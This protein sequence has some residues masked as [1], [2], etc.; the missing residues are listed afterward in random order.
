MQDQNP[1]NP[2]GVFPLQRKTV[3]QEILTDGFVFFV[4]FYSGKPRFPGLCPGLAL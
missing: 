4:K 3:G 1:R 2:A